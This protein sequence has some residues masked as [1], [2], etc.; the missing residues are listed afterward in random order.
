MPGSTLPGILLRSHLGRRLAALVG[1]SSPKRAT[2]E[3][4]SCRWSSSAGA[5][6]E[7]QTGTD[8]RKGENLVG[9]AI[10]PR[11]LL[12]RSGGRPA[13]FAPLDRCGIIVLV[14]RKRQ[15]GAATHTREAPS[16]VHS[17]VVL[18][19]GGP[20]AC[21][22]WYPFVLPAAVACLGWPPVLDTFAAVSVGRHLDKERGHRCD[23]FLH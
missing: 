14:S 10:C 22:R 20:S 5:A 11:P 15:R 3:Y 19:R 13:K 23:G 8:L 4:E 6:E 16:A 17:L 21:I 12:G 18:S 1:T 7:R 2:S 9:R